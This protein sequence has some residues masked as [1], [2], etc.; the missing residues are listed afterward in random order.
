MA[1]EPT[2]GQS[3]WA[4]I[5]KWVLAPIPALILIALAIVLVAM[6]F[7]ELK[8]G[9]LLSWLFGKKDSKKAIDVA[10]SI[11]EGRVDKSGRL[12]QPGTPDSKGVTQAVVVPIHEPGLFSDP[13]T[14]KVTPPGENKPIVVSLPDGVKAKDVDKV[15]MVKPEVYVVTVKDSSKVT[16][17]KVD[18]LL[19]KYGEVDDEADTPR[20]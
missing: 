14:V 1:A 9:G 10:N 13:S 4:W 15:V 16:S 7:K 5:R 20:F 18:D 12:I 11:P 3:V 2:F 19:A 8:I 6:G 17:K